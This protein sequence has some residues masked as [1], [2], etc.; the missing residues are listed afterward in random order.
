VFIEGGIYHVYN[1]FAR[2]AEIFREDGEP[3][4]FAD[5]LRDARYRDGLTVFAWCLMSNH[6]HLAVRTGPVPLWRT[7]GTVQARFGRDYN[8]R[9]A[10]KGPLWQSRYNARL[11]E[12]QHYLDRLIAYIHLNPVSAGLVSD[13]S[14]YQFSGHNE[15]LGTNSGILVDAD[16]V[17]A[18]F[19]GTAR[20]ARRRY[21]GALLGARDEAWRTELPGR[22]PWWGR[23]PD[24]PVKP[25]NPPAW[26][27]ELG[28]S[29]G[30]E[31]S[32]VAARSFFEAASRA[33]AVTP[34]QLASHSSERSLTRLR[35]LVVA[36]GVE[37]W[38][39]STKRLADLLGRRADVVSRW[40]RWGGELRQTDNAFRLDFE[41]LDEALATGFKRETS[42]GLK[43]AKV[44]ALG[45]KR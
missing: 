9:H 8:R 44:S 42:T 2:G 22:L 31:R 3:R 4:R 20:T 27:D 17:L 23:E 25:A 11:V 30:L 45:P 7:V 13:P 10:S 18:A 33:L 14:D 16:S 28:R 19:G 26:V 1:R 40:V 24:R 41:A 15:V 29:T 39:Q 35:S 37:R 36:L 32:R 43:N 12:D 21:V 5:L 38:E 34:Q 6:Y